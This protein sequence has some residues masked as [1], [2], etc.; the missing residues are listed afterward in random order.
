M[1]ELN[2]NHDIFIGCLPCLLCIEVSGLVSLLIFSGILHPVINTAGPVCSCRHL[3]SD[4][5]S[6]QNIIQNIFT[7]KEKDEHSKII[8]RTDVTNPVSE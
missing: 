7:R 8:F 4:V 6:Q 2:I 5:A 1:I 3:T